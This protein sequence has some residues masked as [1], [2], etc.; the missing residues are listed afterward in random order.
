MK[1]NVYKVIFH[2][3]FNGISSIK[4]VTHVVAFYQS[5]A[6]AQVHKR[7]PVDVGH[8]LIVDKIKCVK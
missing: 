7:W 5:D 8:V 6:C 3:E 4:N 1:P 2:T